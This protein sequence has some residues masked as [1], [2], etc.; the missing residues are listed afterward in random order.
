M[1]TFLNNLGNAMVRIALLVSMLYL[2]NC[3]DS[4]EDQLKPNMIILLADDLGY[5]DLGC[6][7]GPIRTPNLDALAAD[8]L[9]FTDFYAAAPNC[10]PSRAGLLT[11][12]S[13]SKVGVYN[14]LAE[15]HPMHLRDREVTLAEVAKKASYHTAHFG[16]WH[17]S[18]LPQN[19]DLM[20]PQPHDQGFDYSFGTANNARPSHL[21]P[22]NFVLNGE[23]L[24]ELHGYACELVANKS[25]EWLERIVVEDENPFFLYA[26]FHEP[27]KVVAAPSDLILN[28]SEY[29]KQDAEYFACV[30][31]MDRAIGKIIHFLRDRELL[32]NTFLLFASDNG[33]YRNGSNGDLLGG[34]SFVYEGGIRVPGI[35]HFPSQ[36]ANPGIITEAVGLIDI[37]PTI[38]EI[39]DQIYAEEVELDG[40]SLMPLIMGKPFIRKKPMSWFFYRTSPEMAM[41]IGD[42]SILGKD[43]NSTLHTHPMTQ[44]DMDVI[45]NMTLDT[46]EIYDLREDPAQSK[47]LALAADEE[48]SFRSQVVGRLK[49]IQATG[50]YW[51]DLPPATGTRKLKH[52]WRALKPSGFSN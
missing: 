36:M 37:M 4:Y 39:T 35:L 51:N 23:R 21:N 9:L 50:P 46:F 16:K 13:P 8:G 41:R 14:Y 30:E 47:K 18:C 6:F 10:S 38:L 49:E 11:G 20:Q 7:G 44:P 32:E 1:G 17:V 25:I 15:Y 33:S 12:R 2:M 26:A 48:R 19:T 5:G 42:Y 28:Y 22:T 52:E 40:Q 34:K 27:H 45:K 29:S 43:L 3:T 24:G 31:N